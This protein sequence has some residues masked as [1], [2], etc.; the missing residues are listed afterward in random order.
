VKLRAMAGVAVLAAGLV[1]AAVPAGAKELPVAGLAVTT[2]HP[3]AGRPIHVVVEFGPGFALGNVT[4]VTEFEVSVLPAARAGRHGWPRDN[5]HLGAPVVIHAV[6]ATEYKGEFVVR[7]PGDY[8]L[9]SRSGVY[10]REDAAA[11][12]TVDEP[13][14][15]PVAFRVEAPN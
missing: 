13:Y 4:A 8:L 11:G 12:V 3:V 15:A 14:V 6:S 2:R 7:H 5:D 1:G 9:V 10:A